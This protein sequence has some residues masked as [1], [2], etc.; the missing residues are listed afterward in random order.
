MS[1]AAAWMMTLLLC[2]KGRR[3]RLIAELSTAGVPY[4]TRNRVICH[5]C[6]S[7]GAVGE[8]V[9]HDQLSR[10]SVIDQTRNGDNEDIKDLIDIGKK[11]KKKH[12]SCIN[13]M[14][15]QSMLNNESTAFVH[16]SL[17]IL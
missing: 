16:S 5:F 11:K 10:K 9:D 4:L 15:T 14:A 8:T 13:I 1:V 12:S 7:R 2:G 17:V 3:R 6:T